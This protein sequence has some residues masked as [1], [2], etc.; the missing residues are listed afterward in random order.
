M[1]GISRWMIIEKFPGGP[2]GLDDTLAAALGE[3]EV[4]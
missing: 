3:D 2:V 4:I 1:T